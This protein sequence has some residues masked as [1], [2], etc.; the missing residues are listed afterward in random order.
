MPG[1]IATLR[2]VCGAALLLSVLTPGAAL[3]T[4]ISVNCVPTKLDIV[5][6]KLDHSSRLS[7][8]FGNIPQG[9]VNFV[10]GGAKPSCVIVSFSAS[11]QSSAGTPVVIRAR[12][13][14]GMIARPDYVYYS[15]EDGISGGAHVYEF[16]FPNLAPGT[17]LLN[18]Q[19]KSLNG[20]PVVVNRHTTIVRH[21]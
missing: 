1:K 8:V 4:Q 3:A 9:S 15:E 21:K 17:Y 5:V 18:M 12:L 7:I 19:F 14:N 13:T 11:T 10:H 6:S 2:V 20:N 16:L